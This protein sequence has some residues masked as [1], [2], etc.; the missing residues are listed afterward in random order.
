MQVVLKETE[1]QPRSMFQDPL[2]VR[3]RKYDV[4]HA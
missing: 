3:P 1:G 2:L 4:H